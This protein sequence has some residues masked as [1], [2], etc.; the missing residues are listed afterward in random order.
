MSRAEYEKVL[1]YFD[2]VLQL[3]PENDQAYKHLKNL[4]KAKDIWNGDP[5]ENQKEVS[6]EI[7]KA[8]GDIVMNKKTIKIRDFL[9]NARVTAIKSA[10]WAWHSTLKLRCALMFGIQV[11]LTGKFSVKSPKESNERKCR[12]RKSF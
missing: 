8:G 2:I 9:N 4:Q 11:L 1:K 7:D 5:K 3:H 6:K 10:Y 12:R